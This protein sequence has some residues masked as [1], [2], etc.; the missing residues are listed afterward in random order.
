MLHSIKANSL[1]FQLILVNGTYS[2]E[3]CVCYME[4]GVEAGHWGCVENDLLPILHH[5]CH[6]AKLKK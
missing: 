5:V 3:P 6:I 4:A 1:S 2:E